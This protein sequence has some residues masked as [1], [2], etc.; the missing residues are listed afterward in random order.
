MHQRYYGRYAH[1]YG[2]P[3]HDI[4]WVVGLSVMVISISQYLYRYYRYHKI[5]GYAKN[6][7]RYKTHLKKLKGNGEKNSSKKKSEEPE[8]K[9][10]ELEF[11]IVGAEPARMA[12]VLLVQLVLLPYIVPRGLYRAWL[13]YVWWRFFSPRDRQEEEE[14]EDEERRKKS[15][16]SQVEWDR[17]KRRGHE[18]LERF[19]TSAKA[20]RIR[21]FMRNRESVVCFD[22]D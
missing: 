10:E 20:K 19:R 3:D 7:Q 2:A 15:G 18:K 11:E 8:E 22:E 13:R 16:M 17:A 4:R 14:E 9:E 1:K 5:R 12:D 21:R 6:S